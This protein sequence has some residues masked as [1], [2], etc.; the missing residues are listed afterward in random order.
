M[1]QVS[2]FKMFTVASIKFRFLTVKNVYYWRQALDEQFLGIKVNI[3][4][5][6]FRIAFSKKKNMLSFPFSVCSKP[7]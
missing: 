6:K 4:S 3:F 5:T 7:S 1:H 2:P